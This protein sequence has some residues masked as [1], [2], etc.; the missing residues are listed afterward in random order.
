M[1]ADSEDPDD[2][3]ESTFCGILP[4]ADSDSDESK[5]PLIRAHLRIGHCVVRLRPLRNLIPRSLIVTI[6]MLFNIFCYPEKQT[7]L[8]TCLPTLKYLLFPKELH[9]S[10]LHMPSNAF[11]T[12]R[13]G[14]NKPSQP[15]LT[16]Y[17]YPPRLRQN[18]HQMLVALLNCIGI[19]GQAVP[20]INTVWIG[21]FLGKC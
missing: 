2:P 9:G 10:F 5:P 19:S 18:N 7:F 17:S 1:E 3:E 13:S 14:I 20:R 4:H 21:K 12:K 8:D 11:T 6:V 15:Y 16:A